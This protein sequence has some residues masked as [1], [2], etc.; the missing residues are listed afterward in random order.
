MICG[1]WWV[2]LN[3]Q[4]EMVKS[5]IAFDQF[6]GGMFAMTVLSLK[7]KILKPIRHFRKN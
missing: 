3:E 2:R 6:A 5:N 1:R 7:L 4:I